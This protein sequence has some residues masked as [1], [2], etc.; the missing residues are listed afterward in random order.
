MANPRITFLREI[1][2]EYRKD[3]GL[4]LVNNEQVPVTNYIFS[5]PPYKPLI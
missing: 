4:N 3:T 1:T 2:Y 5:L